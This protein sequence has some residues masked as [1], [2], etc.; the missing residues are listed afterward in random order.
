MYSHY[1]YS[2]GQQQ[3]TMSGAVAVQQG[4]MTWNGSKWVNDP[5][6]NAAPGGY[7]YQNASSV[8]MGSNQQFQSASTV[9]Q[10]HQG[11]NPADQYKRYW[12]YW[13]DQA[14]SQ[15]I[16]A[17]SLHPGP[18]KEEA[19]RVAAWADYYAN[20][21]ASAVQYYHN[22]PAT[23]QQPPPRLPANVA[24]A[25]PVIATP[26]AAPSPAPAPTPAPTYKSSTSSSVLPYS[27]PAKTSAPVQ[28]SSKG[29]DQDEY[30]NSLK[31][32]MRR[33]LS[34]C[35][36][37]KER[38]AAQEAVEKEVYK[39]IANNTMS[40]TDWESKPLP[41][42][43]LN[44]FNASSSSSSFSQS[45]SNSSKSS[46]LSPYSQPFV[47][48]NSPTKNSFSATESS[49][50]KKKPNSKSSN[51]KPNTKFKSFIQE[52]DY[53]QLMPAN[54]SYYGRSSSDNDSSSKSTTTSNQVLPPPKK[55]K[56]DSSPMAHKKLKVE[57][58]NQ[59][60][61]SAKK[62]SQSSQDVRCSSS[63]DGFERSTTAL[64]RRANRFCISDTYS[65]KKTSEEKK[66]GQYMGLSVI[67]GGS[68]GAARLDEND[69]EQMTVKGTCQTLEKEYLRLTQPPKECMVRPQPILEKHLRNLKKKW[70]NSKCEYLW[71]CSQIKAIRQDLRVQRLFN[72]FAVEVYETHA[73][74]AL[75]QEDLN[76]YNQ[77]QTQLQELYEMLESK[78]DDED[79]SFIS[80]GLQNQNEFI[81]Y[82][83]IY[84]VF[85]TGNKKYEGGSSDL[86]KIMLSLTPD[87]RREPCIAHA[88]KV[89]VAVAE[90]DYYAFFRLH[91][92]CP[93]MGAYLMDFMVPTI[94]L[95]AL[96]RI[97]RAYRPNVPAKF[98]LSELGFNVKDIREYDYALD[99]IKSC[100]IS[101]EEGMI[102]TKD[103]VV[104]SSVPTDKKNSLI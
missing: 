40:T 52:E 21:S 87:Q 101:I 22:Y 14:K 45:F 19:L 32:Y 53:I 82:R 75:E 8:P 20:Q 7:G 16:K 49:H 11:E 99:W 71:L 56:Q 102:N 12:T 15:R 31:Q 1:S 67:G 100:G 65:P 39:A 28:R 96:Q 92:S 51:S 24:P 72:D 104:Q 78:R 89:R 44:K 4:G 30:P 36:T 81:A 59:S 3:Q 77:C 48:K 103:S 98:I 47:V 97:V 80:K 35:S 50:S 94:R 76:E 70:I 91:D 88:L 2:H 69:Y 27:T 68:K 9:L 58:N 25:P 42:I 18:E 26:I 83:I 85:L 73:R 54:D 23:S 34:K 79:H 66:I 95:T 6:V 29:N 33:V 46:S 55:K 86:F 43:V 37:D 17:E 13:L 63:Q 74:I 41:D 60:K 38:K 90:N 57:L 84:Y 5:S 64:A 61:K 93:K 62:T 10:P